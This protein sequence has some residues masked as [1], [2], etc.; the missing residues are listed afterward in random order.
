MPRIA[1]SNDKSIRP[2]SREKERVAAAGGQDRPAYHSREGNQL[3]HP[4]PHAPM[5]PK[6]P[7]DK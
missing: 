7:A 3:A 5:S 1:V 2:G 4:T 6:F